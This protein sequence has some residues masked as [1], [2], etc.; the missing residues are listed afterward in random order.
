MGECVQIDITHKEVDMSIFAL[1]ALIILSPFMA[2]SLL[3]VL[4]DE[5]DENDEKLVR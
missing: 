5:K 4:R 1:I 3:P 2:S